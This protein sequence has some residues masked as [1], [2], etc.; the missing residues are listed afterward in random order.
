MAKK[1]QWHLKEHPPLPCPPFPPRNT[2]GQPGPER[3]CTGVLTQPAWL[4]SWRLASEASE[5]V[6]EA[7][8]PVCALPL[9]GQVS[10]RRPGLKGGGPFQL[11]TSQLWFITEEPQHWGTH[12]SPLAAELKNKIEGR[13]LCTFPCLFPYQWPCWHLWVCGG[14]LTFS[15]LLPEKGTEFPIAQLT[16]FPL[17]GHVCTLGLDTVLCVY[18]RKP[19]R[20]WEP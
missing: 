15:M 11:F 16:P 8:G 18:V 20:C 9:N 10:P 4:Q 12:I 6:E 5:E 2:F 3:C 1:D 17:S 13:L 14:W 19:L 7:G